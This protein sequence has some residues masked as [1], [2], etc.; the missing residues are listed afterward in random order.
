[1]DLKI[2]INSLEGFSEEDTHLLYKALRL[3][4]SILNSQEFKQRWLQAKPKHNKGFSQLQIYNQIM[5][6][7]SRFEEIVDYELDYF[8]RK[9]KLKRGTLAST[10]MSTGVIVI[11]LLQFNY[12]KKLE[13]GHVYLSSCLF[14]EALHSQHGFT[15]PW[16]PP[17]WKRRSVPYIGGNIVRELGEQVVRGRKLTSVKG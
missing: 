1:M 7:Q 2:K 4:E 17:S 9:Y 3:Q 15:H 10:A 14:H 16:F 12:W 13:N 11:N 5:K 6:G 8:L